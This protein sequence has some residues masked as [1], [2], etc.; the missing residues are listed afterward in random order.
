ME[1]ETK[2]PADTVRIVVNMNR[3]EYRSLVSSLALQGKKVSGWLRE[4]AHAEII[5]HK[6]L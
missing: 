3:N 5:K 4:Q 1:K 6:G 2:Q